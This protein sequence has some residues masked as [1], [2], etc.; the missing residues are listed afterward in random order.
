MVNMARSIVN[1][2][3]EMHVSNAKSVRGEN[4][5]AI[6]MCHECARV[7]CVAGARSMTT[8]HER[9]TRKRKTEMNRI[10]S[11]I[12]FIAHTHTHAHTVVLVKLQ[13]NE[14]AIKSIHLCL[15]ERLGVCSLRVAR[16]L[17]GKKTK[18]NKNSDSKN[19]FLN[20]YFK[21]LQ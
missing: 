14:Q 20:L 9:M 12:S 10:L 2:V 1:N 16:C 3:C 13:R 19:V 7:Q 4:S 15:I 11:V 6:H 17:L 21:L 18:N 8:I 5:A